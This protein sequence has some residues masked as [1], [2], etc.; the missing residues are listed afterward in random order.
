MIPT[1]ICPSAT[2]IDTITSNLDYPFRVFGSNQKKI[3]RKVDGLPLIGIHVFMNPPYEAPDPSGKETLVSYSEVESGLSSDEWALLIHGMFQNH[4]S[5]FARGSDG[6]SLYC[7]T[8]I[9][10]TDKNGMIYSCPILYFYGEEFSLKAS[11]KNPS[12]L[13]V[14]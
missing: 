1:V 12:F 9:V 11:R 6:R 14:K 8:V 2:A 4:F 13:K 3:D 5:P 7:R 10:L